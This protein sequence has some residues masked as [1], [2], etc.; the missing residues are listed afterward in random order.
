VLIPLSAGLLAAASAFVA[1]RAWRTCNALA[2]APLLPADEDELERRLLE[3]ERNLALNLARRTIQAARRVALFGGTAL[4][5]LALTGGTKYDLW[6]SAWAFLLGLTS[7]GA[8][9]ELERRAGSVADKWREITNKKRHLEAT[10]SG[11]A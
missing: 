4:A 5:F 8:C 6:S 1:V 11:P 2:S 10:R 7:W 9:G 3:K